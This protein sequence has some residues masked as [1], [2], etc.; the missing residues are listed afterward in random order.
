[1]LQRARH[2]ATHD[3]MGYGLSDNSIEMTPG[4]FAVVE[5]GSTLADTGWV[6]SSDTALAAGNTSTEFEF[7]QF[8][9]AGMQ[10]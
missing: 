7:T 3:G 10:T 5:Q 1:M 8:S 6:M 9:S 4:S 2:D